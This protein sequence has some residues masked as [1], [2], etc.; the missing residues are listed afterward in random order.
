MVTQETERNRVTE[1]ISKGAKNYLIKP[2]SKEDLTG[3]I[4][5]SLGLKL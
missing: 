2:F 5:E 1:A 3:K 4:M